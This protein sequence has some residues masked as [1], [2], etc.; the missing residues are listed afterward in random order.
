MPI[1]E[2]KAVSEGCLP[3]AN[4]PNSSRFTPLLA[5]HVQGSEH[6]PLRIPRRLARPLSPGGVGFSN[7]SSRLGLRPHSHLLSVTQV[8]AG[9]Q[10]GARAGAVPRR[11]LWGWSLGRRLEGPHCLPPFQLS[12]VPEADVLPLRV[13]HRRVIS[14]E[15]SGSERFPAC[16]HLCRRTPK[17]VLRS[18]DCA[19][20]EAGAVYHCLPFPGS[21]QP[22]TLR[23]WGSAGK[24][25]LGICWP[26]PK[27][28]SEVL[29]G[30]KLFFWS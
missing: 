8:S 9:A 7:H 11:L 15:G 18:R 1:G 22:H 10:A 26:G 27:P 4:H 29:S 23:G 6:P 21:Q 30:R 17:Q 2:A 3:S 12:A 16:G 14:G 24:W 19:C 28:L 20:R 25:V 5:S 13:P